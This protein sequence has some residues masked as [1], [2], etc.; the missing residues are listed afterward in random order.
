[1]FQANGCL[2]FT[3]CW[4]QTLSWALGPCLLPPLLL[5]FWCFVSP[6]VITLPLPFLLGHKTTTEVSSAI[7]SPSP[8]VHLPLVS[9]WPP[10][11]FV[12]WLASL[13]LPSDPVHA[14][15][16]LDCTLHQVP[17]QG[18]ALGGMV[19]ALNKCVPLE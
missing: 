1:M 10:G 13:L 18:R 3:A 14:A 15:C 11:R 9:L 7:C 12:S 2:H 6:P 5:E 19:G 8:Y 16:P 17:I 4:I